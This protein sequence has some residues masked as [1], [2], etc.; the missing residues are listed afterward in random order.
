MDIFRELNSM[1][2]SWESEN[3]SKK[4]IINNRN[5]I[6]KVKIEIETIIQP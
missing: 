5:P 6:V 1:L 3:K 4:Y 2:Y